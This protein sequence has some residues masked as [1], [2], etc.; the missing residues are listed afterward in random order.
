MEIGEKGLNGD[1]EITE[2]KVT[3]AID[4]VKKKKGKRK[5]KRKDWW[6]E[7]CKVKKR[8]VRRELREW[9]RKGK[10]DKRVQER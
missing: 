5:E 1:W 6:N 2:E 9:R 10:E 4:D 8:K 3:R 7:E